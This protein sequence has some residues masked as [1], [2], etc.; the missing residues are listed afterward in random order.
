MLVFV[1]IDMVFCCVM[2]CILHILMHWTLCIYVI[3]ATL[4]VNVKPI[5]INSVNVL[6]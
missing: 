6:T 2:K 1:L 4:C 5:K 3:K